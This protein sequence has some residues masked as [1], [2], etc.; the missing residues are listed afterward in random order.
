M[1]GLARADRERGTVLAL[2][3]IV[4]VALAMRAAPGVIGPVFPILADDLGID[5][6]VLSI[7]GAAPPFGFALAGLLVPGATRRFGLEGSLIGAVA[8]IGAGQAVRAAASEP[9]LLVAAT[10]LIMVGIG[11]ANV[12]LPPLVRRY[13]PR[14]IG[15]VTGC[16]LVLMSISASAPAFV[17][18][19]LAEAAGWRLAIGVWAVLPALAIV[20]WVA[21]VVHRR[22][23][24]A[25][26]TPPEVD[27]VAGVREPGPVTRAVA[28][29]RL[30]AASPTAWAIMGTLVISS[31]TIYAAMAFLPSMLISA[32]GLRAEAAGA[33]LG[34]ALVLGIPQA[35]L[36]PLVAARRGATI[37]LIAAA[38]AF[39]VIGWGGMLLAPA[40]APFLWALSVGSGSI[41]FPLALL[42]VNTRTRDH[43][44]TVSVSAFAQ[45]AA[46]L[47]AG[48][49]SIVL[50]VIHQLTGSWTVP[51]VVLAATAAISVPVILVLRRGRMIDDELG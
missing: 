38:A 21:T 18:V 4:V 2:L 6:V 48:V 37:P 43:R 36:V 47:T 44:V 39:T 23:A 19:Q 42:L 27:E 46:Y 49:F 30:I 5:V 13:A 34:L 33:A 1:N 26:L 35:L 45:G 17:G 8:L 51:F 16:Y 22:A 11:A 12:L 28:R 32:A 24:P 9:I 40:A 14:R 29:P 41:V 50:G 15:L 3:G 7:L 31:I 10:F 20:P 25:E